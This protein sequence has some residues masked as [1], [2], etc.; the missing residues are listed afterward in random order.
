MLSV[1]KLMSPIMPYVTEE[2]YH[3]YFKKDEKDRP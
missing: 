2:L 1:L 3:A